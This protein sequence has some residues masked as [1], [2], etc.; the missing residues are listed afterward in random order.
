MP[1]TRGTER[2]SIVNP[3]PRPHSVPGVR[4]RNMDFSLTFIIILIVVSSSEAQISFGSSSDNNNRNTV[5]EDDL[6][7]SLEPSAAAATSK[8]PTVSNGI[9]FSS[10]S[11]KQLKKNPHKIDS[12]RVLLKDILK[13]EGQDLKSPVVNTRFGFGTSVT[14]KVGQ[15][16]RT[17]LSEEGTCQVR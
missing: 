17:P 10:T 8:L 12:K 1:E 3:R 16:C 14:P 6:I 5:S 9:S 15:S 13:L 4:F 2:E 7:L 11:R